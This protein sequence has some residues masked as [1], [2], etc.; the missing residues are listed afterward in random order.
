MAA[1]RKGPFQ[2]IKGLLELMC[3]SMTVS[4]IAILGSA[5]DENSAQRPI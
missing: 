4:V 3:T 5:A 1:I 2:A